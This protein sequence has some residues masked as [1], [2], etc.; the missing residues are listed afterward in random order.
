MTSVEMLAR[1]KLSNFFATA[2]ATKKK[3]S[4]VTSATDRHN[5]RDRHVRD[6]GRHQEGQGGEA[7]GHD[8]DGGRLR[9]DQV[10]SVVVCHLGEG[11]PRRGSPGAN[12][13]KTFFFHHKNR[14]VFVLGNFN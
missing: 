13:T 1:G 3:K 12:V 11:H 7:G 6:E 9:V 14:L 2:S 4:F 8:D 10:G 5:V